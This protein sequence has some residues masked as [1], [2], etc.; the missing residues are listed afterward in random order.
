MAYSLIRRQMIAAYDGSGTG[1]MEAEKLEIYFRT[2]GKARP[3]QPIRV[4][5]PGWLGDGRNKME[6]GSEPQPWHCRPTVEGAV[7]GLELVYQYEVECHIINDG[8]RVRIEWDY[9][10]E[11]GGVLGID[12]FGFGDNKLPDF[13]TFGTSLDIQAPP[14]FVLQTQPHPRFFDDRTGTVP[15]AL[16]GQVQSEWWPKKLFAVFKNPPPGGRHIF[17][18]GEPYAQIIFVPG[19]QKLEVKPMTAEQASAR[20]ELENGILYAKSH[21]ARNIWC[22]PTGGQFDDHYKV[23][24]RTFAEEGHA[25]VQ[26]AIRSAVDRQRRTVPPDLSFAEYMG[27]A[28]RHL[29]EGK[30]IEARDVY[31]HLRSLDRDNPQVANGLGAAAAAMGLLDLAVQALA[32]AVTA[33][34]RTALYRANLGAVLLRQGR[35]AEAEASLRAALRLDPK[36][37]EALASLR[38]LTTG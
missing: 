35:L 32:F 27:L 3:P 2:A 10:R 7:Y 19:R 30:P 31:F 9:A 14:G 26:N 17:R 28:T 29:A 16:I 8:G 6:H 18:K 11:P 23:L 20:Q 12:E 38:R 5:F 22:S 4:T 37:A 13:Y 21:I 34:P 15:L 24:A 1:A 33:D 36:N 25:G